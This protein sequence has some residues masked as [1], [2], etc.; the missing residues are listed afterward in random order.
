MKIKEAEYQARLKAVADN[1][2]A[3]RSEEN[4]E[5][6]SKSEKMAK[7]ILECGCSDITLTGVLKQL[8]IVL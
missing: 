2:E 4:W 1:Y 5:E 3:L 6:M 8:N 7:M